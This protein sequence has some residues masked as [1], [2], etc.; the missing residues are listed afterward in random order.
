MAL[1]KEKE[2]DMIPCDGLPARLPG[3]PKRILF[4]MGKER[5]AVGRRLHPACP[6]GCS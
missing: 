3:T 5:P 2:R 1:R 6:A 4:H